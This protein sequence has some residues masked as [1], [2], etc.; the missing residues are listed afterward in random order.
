MQYMLCNNMQYTLCNKA[1][2]LYAVY[3]SNIL[4]NIEYC[5]HYLYLV[6][7]SIRYA[8]ICSVHYA[9]IC[10]IHYA[11]ICSTVYTMQYKYYAVYNTNI[12]YCMYYLVIS[13]MQYTLCNNMQY[14]LCNNMQYTLCN[15]IEL[16]NA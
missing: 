10:S 4:F 11:I 8:I 6:V 13:S 14:T 16:L 12:Q 15:N 3:N 5:M 2:A 7:C 1:Y 9:I